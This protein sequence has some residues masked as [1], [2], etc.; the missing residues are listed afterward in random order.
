VSTP[1]TLFDV[2][3]PL[4]FFTINRPDA[5][6]AMTWDMYDAL[7]RACDE[8]NA[9]DDLRVFVIRAAGDR[10]FIAGTDI[11]QFTVF[12]SPEAALAYERRLDGVIDRVERVRIPTIAQVQGVA[13]G[14][15]CAIALACD[16]RVCTEDARFGIPIARTLGNCLSAANYAR[17]L[18]LLGPAR[19]KELLFTGRLIDVAEAESLGLVTR[20]ATSTDIDGVVRRLAA[21]IAAHAP[22]TIRATKEAVR[23]IQEHRRIPPALDDDLI[24][25]CYTSDDFKEGV[26]AFLARRPPQFRGR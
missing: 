17:L 3:G 18:D 12:D 1:H 21:D 25:L 4:A 11:S 10:A 7:V 2:D 5:R 9:R 15:G 6:N 16:M 26:A 13:A 23:R 20:M 19:T 22:L 8:V 14:G 24:T